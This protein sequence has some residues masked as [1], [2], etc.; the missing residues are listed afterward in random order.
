MPEPSGAA[1]A[2]LLLS[3]V[4]LRAAQGTKTIAYVFADGSHESQSYA[5]LLLDARRILAGHTAAGAR[6]AP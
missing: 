2:P 6:G 1:D 4:L 5:A 3:D